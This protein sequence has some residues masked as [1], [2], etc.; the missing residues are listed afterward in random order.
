MISNSLVYLGQAVLCSKISGEYINRLVMWA[1]NVADAFR[2]SENS[3]QVAIH[4]LEL[5]YATAKSTT[6]AKTALLTSQRE[7]DDRAATALK[8]K[9]D[10]EESKYNEILVIKQ[11]EIT[12]YESMLNDLGLMHQ[13]TIVAL[14]E[15]IQEYREKLMTERNNVLEEQ[16]RLGEGNDVFSN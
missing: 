2:K 7:N 12:R 1:S 11:C 9:I 5:D 13:K 16:R 14:E 6:E 15:R 8:E 4:K 10:L 3:L